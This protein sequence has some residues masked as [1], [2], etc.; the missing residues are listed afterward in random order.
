MTTTL[1]LTV[2]WTQ[3]G[4]GPCI[5][6]KRML[7]D[8]GVTFVTMDVSLADAPRVARWR[9]LNPGKNVST[10]IIESGGLVIMGA[11]PDRIAALT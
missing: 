7:Q 3:A 6:A 8:A 11:D 5:A 1:A 2:L 9:R 4:C 10:P